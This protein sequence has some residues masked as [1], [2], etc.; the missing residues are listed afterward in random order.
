MVFLYV[1]LVL[2]VIGCAGATGWAVA[3]R[4]RLEAA[5]RRLLSRSVPPPPLAVIPPTRID[6]PQ[7]APPAPVIRQEPTPPPAPAPL[8][9]LAA[10]RALPNLSNVLDPQPDSTVDGARLGRMVVRAAATRGEFNRLDALVRRQAATVTVLSKFDPPVLLSCVA[11]GLP[12]SEHSH[13][14]AVQACR[15][16]HGRLNERAATL[17]LDA[18][19]KDTNGA[20]SS[21]DEDVRRLLRDAVAE[22]GKSLTLAAAG[23]NMEPEMVSTSLTFLLSRLGDTPRRQHLVASVGGGVLLRMSGEGTWSTEYEATPPTA[24]LPENADLVTWRAVNSGPH[25]VLVLCSATTASFLQRDKVK[26]SL[27]AGW[28]GAPPDLVQFFWYLNQADPAREDHAAV[29]IWELPPPA[30]S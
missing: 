5:E 14:G 1:V 13:L 4:Q 22:V 29:G 23:R 9:D 10:P 25:D 12:S 28:Q 15:T 8:A 11:A 16:L 17:A 26:A 7:P 21:A 18:A 19:W 30:V 27:T 6:P 20:V 3:L 24:A 2:L